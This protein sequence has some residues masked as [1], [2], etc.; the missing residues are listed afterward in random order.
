MQEL[1][2][3]VFGVFSAGVTGQVI[4]LVIRLVSMP[5]AL[6]CWGEQ[7]YG[8]WLILLTVPSYL[9][10]SGSGLSV[11][12]A[13]EMV[14]KT[15]KGKQQEALC[16]F[17]SIWVF[18]SGTALVFVV[19]AFLATLLF[20]VSRWFH[21]VH[22]PDR[23]TRIALVLLA[24]YT[25]CILQ[26]E[27]FLGSFR[28]GRFVNGVLL[29][30]LINLLENTGLLIAVALSSNVLIAVGVYVAIR[31]LSTGFMAYQLLK[32]VP[33][34]QLGTRHARYK[35]VRSILLPT[36]SQFGINISNALSVQGIL[37]VIGLRLGA[38]AVVSFTAIRAIVNMVKQFNSMIYNAFMPEFSTTLSAGNLSL[39]GK[40]HRY[41][42][43]ISLY[44]TLFNI[45]VLL[46]CGPMIIR[47]WTAGKL[48]VDYPFFTLML[49]S[50]LPNTFYVT[51]AY[52]HVS[53][54]RLGKIAVICLL[55]SVLSV[56]FT[57]ATIPVLGIQAAP[58]MQLLF[59]SILV[60][61]IVRDSLL[62]LNDNTA[63]FIQSLF[64]FHHVRQIKN[65][66]K[67]LIPYKRN[68]L[69]SK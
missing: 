25:F 56:C 8:E 42:C 57:Y 44:F 43:Q 61:L 58:L 51:S 67:L 68:P 36:L 4:N 65:I 55:A 13:N 64:R 28:L 15:T 49:L 33:W 60:V 27:L 59:D 38:P 5:V 34:L 3:R 26:S 41:A 12:A 19:L 1:L 37:T 17:Q 62:L 39:A 45:V 11:I 50:L 46:I 63:D 29:Y 14:M 23:D 21:I 66:R 69:S 24:L 30:N 47:I 54:N 9:A 18:I 31:L 53:I 35:T 6:H 2:R 40:L 52:V 7:L 48:E 22:I 10:V 32:Q 16:V 20:P